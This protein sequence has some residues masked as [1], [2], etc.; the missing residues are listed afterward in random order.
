MNEAFDP[1][2]DLPVRFGGLARR[3]AEPIASAPVEGL[4]TSGDPLPFPLFGGQ[5]AA[6]CLATTP[7]AGEL[8]RVER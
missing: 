2:Q 6:S 1:L 3:P 7:L 8:S 5:S 4:H